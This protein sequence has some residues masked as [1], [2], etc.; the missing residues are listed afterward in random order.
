LKENRLFVRLLIR[1]NKFPKRK[2]IRLKDHDYLVNGYYFITICSKNRQNIF[3]QYVGADGCRP[4]NNNARIK[5]NEYGL[6]VEEELKNSENIR[7]E[8]IL[9]HYII[10]SN[11]LHAI[12]I[13]NHDL[14]GG[15]PAAPTDHVNRK[16]T[17]SSFVAGFK[18]IATKRINILR[19]TPG[20]PVWQRSFYDH[21]IRNEHSL[22]AIREYISNNPVNWEQD[23][24]NL[25][26]L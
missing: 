19:N 16:Q 10:M 14:S 13:I 6:I 18:S 25:I 9:D 17:L 3:G 24:D 21:I 8:I 2:P 11:H 12:I 22:N 23:I 15:R 20:Q 26:N 4:D 7:N 5:L 1:M